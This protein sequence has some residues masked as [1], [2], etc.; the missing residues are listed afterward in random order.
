MRGKCG[1]NDNTECTNQTSWPGQSIFLC[2]DHV[3]TIPLNKTLSISVVAKRKTD[4]QSTIRAVEALKAILFRD[5][6]ESRNSFIKVHEKRNNSVSSCCCCLYV[7]CGHYDSSDHD[8]IIDADTKAYL[9]AT[10]PYCLLK[11]KKKCTDEMNCCIL[12]MRGG[13]STN[14][15][16]ELYDFVRECRHFA[17]E[18][19]AIDFVVECNPFE[20][21]ERHTERYFDYI[22]LR[23]DLS[24]QRLLSTRTL[25]RD[26]HHFDKRCARE[27][28]LMNNLCKPNENGV[29]C[30]TC[31]RQAVDRFGERFVE[32]RPRINKD[33]ARKQLAKRVNVCA[34]NDLYLKKIRLDWC[35]GMIKYREKI[36]CTL[37]F[38]GVNCNQRHNCS[39][40]L[41]YLPIYFRTKL[42]N[43]SHWPRQNYERDHVSN[44][45]GVE[46]GCGMPWQA[47]GQL[48][49]FES[50]CSWMKA[51]GDVICGD[52]D[53]NM[54]EGINPI[55]S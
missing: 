12:T 24:S 19:C 22:D 37:G 36:R 45:N 30:V 3:N 43:T 25:I 38:C 32:I 33:N 42:N 5:G 16:E 52:F 53:S 40:S 20:N 23:Q 34:I 2:R 47:S 50:S 44:V 41:S 54:H 55:T 39:S 17:Y 31:E 49:N 4:K 46:C 14:S 51:T 28:G 35:S 9:K 6:F 21:A 8:K 29:R 26:H 1:A 13:T 27:G 18:M 10:C 7:E 15:V 11:I 48:H